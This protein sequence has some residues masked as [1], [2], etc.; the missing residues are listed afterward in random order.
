M[1]DSIP[2][3]RTFIAVN[4]I[5]PPSIPSPQAHAVPMELD[6]Q[7]KFL[8]S[9]PGPNVPPSFAVRPSLKLRRKK[10]SPKPLRV[11]VSFAASSHEV[12]DTSK[13]ET[14]VTDIGGS[15]WLV[16]RQGIAG[17]KP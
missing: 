1:L 15:M 11:N 5:T 16:L 6:S 2:V 13:H 9:L 3:S 8:G 14:D 10:H 17:L 4:V 7:S 12:K